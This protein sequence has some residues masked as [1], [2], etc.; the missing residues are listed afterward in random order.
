MKTHKN[1]FSKS[2]YLKQKLLFFAKS[3]LKALKVWKLI[4]N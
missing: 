1:L 2:K 3:I 4:F